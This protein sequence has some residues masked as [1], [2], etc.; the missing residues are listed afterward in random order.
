MNFAQALAIYQAG[1][2]AKA[3]KIWQQE[4]QGSAWTGEEKRLAYQYLL[5]IYPPTTA[6]HEQWRWELACCLEE[7]KLWPQ[8]LELF[9]QDESLARLG[10][11]L[12]HIWHC[13]I[14]L[15][16][17]AAAAATATKLLAYYLRTKKIMLGL[18]F[19]AELK[20][21]NFS[22]AEHLKFQIKFWQLQGNLAAL[23]QVVPEMKHPAEILS[24]LRNIADEPALLDAKLASFW[25]QLAGYLGSLRPQPLRPVQKTTATG[26][27]T[28]GATIVEL[29]RLNQAGGPLPARREG[30]K[31]RAPI[32]AETLQ[33]VL[34]LCR[35]FLK[36][37]YLK[38]LFYPAASDFW[39]VLARYAQ[40]FARPKLLGALKNI[41]TQVATDDA[42]GLAEMKTLLAD[43][44]AGALAVAPELPPAETMVGPCDMATDLFLQELTI[45]DLKAARIKRM[46]RDI[47]FLQRQGE[48]KKAAAIL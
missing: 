48:K 30:R 23:A 21:T 10:T 3:V 43:V 18:Q 39:P 27:S 42:P 22:S 46:E 17:V 36:T 47:A 19:L 14:C 11:N 12:H 8:A 20:Q 31:R 33:A 13:Q 26:S 29:H 28:L 34:Q 40:L 32:S 5:Q 25:P 2:T 4:V 38:I 41:V 7:L 24:E 15:G 6:E 44:E 16:Q 35:E 45:A 1:D 9:Y 37:S